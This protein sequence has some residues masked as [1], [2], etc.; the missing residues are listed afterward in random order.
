MPRTPKQAPTPPNSIVASAVTMNGKSAKIPRTRGALAWQEEAWY[1]YDAIGEARYAV[2]YIAN[3]LSRVDLFVVDSEDKRVETGTPFEALEALTKGDPGQIMSGLGANLSCAGEGYL[4]GMEDEDVQGQDDWQVYSALE[5]TPPGNRKGQWT[6]NRGEASGP[7][8]ISP[9]SAIIIRIWR[10]HPRLWAAADSPMRAVLANLREIEALSKHVGATV[11]SRLAGAGIL[12][13]P[14]EMTFST[15]GPQ[16][17]AG[18]QVDPTT[19]PFIASLTTA[20][21]TAIRDRDS[22]EAVTPLVV[23]APGEH[24]ANIQHLTFTSPLD[25]VVK[26]LRDDSVRRFALGIDLPPEVVLGQ[27]D[28]NHWSAWQIDENSIKVHIEPICELIADAITREYLWPA[29]E[30]QRVPNFQS[31]RIAYDTS[32]LRV[33]QDNS[34]SA[35]ALYDRLELSGEALR[36]ETGFQP[37]DQ[38]EDDEVKTMLLRKAAVQV[39]PPEAVLQANKEL[40]VDLVPP[41]TPQQ[42]A[43]QRVQQQIGNARQT[44]IAPGPSV[45][46]VPRLPVNPVAEQRPVPEQQ[47]AAAMLAAC[48]VTALRGIEKARARLNRKRSAIDPAAITAALSGVWDEVP[49]ISELCGLDPAWLTERLNRYA[50]T[51]LADGGQH[52]TAALVQMLSDA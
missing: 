11:D 8:R 40:G 30:G 25:A 41:P 10:R 18:A 5:V 42:A 45:P 12:F 35:L 15:P 6:L 2:N 26:E 38:P 20:M 21:M 16:P 39:L 37:E 51:V 19:D 48:E 27:A 32:E 4:I 9:D 46:Q 17:P 28:S 36:R 23:K 44:Q 50:H 14:A 47:A 31:Y 13:V 33:R 1:F 24:L 43:N 7:R 29:L 52:D 3:S 22:A 49:R 34:T